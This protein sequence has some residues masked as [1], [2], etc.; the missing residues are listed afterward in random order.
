MSCLDAKALQI[1]PEGMAFL[2]RVLATTPDAQPDGVARRR[3]PKRKPA[4][5]RNRAVPTPTNP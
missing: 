1:D 2:R 4:E 5:L 3:A